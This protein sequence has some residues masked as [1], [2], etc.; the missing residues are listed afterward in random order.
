MTANANHPHGAM[1][2]SDREITDRAAIDAIIRS[3]RVMYLALAEADAPF[4]V[5]VFYA[6]D[7]TSL[8]LHSAKSGSKIRI[9]K[10]NPRVCFAISTDHGVIES[11]QAC[12]FEAKHRTVIGMGQAHF[13]TDEAER[14]AI[15]D[16]IVARFTD[17][18]FEY[19]KTNLD[20]TAVIRI[21]I[22]S[23]KGKS[24]GFG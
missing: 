21:N 20:A 18:H 2:R 19:P 8:Y 22:E 11:Q 17:Q 3:A 12:D 14:I 7:G 15:L 6:Y 16:R 10:R 1:R 9:L 4:V 5:P 13:V 24:H 23:I